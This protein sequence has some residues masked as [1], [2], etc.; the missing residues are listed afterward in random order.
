LHRCG[1]IV[2]AACGRRHGSGNW[3]G[4]EETDCN[5]G[6]EEQKAE[7][8]GTGSVKQNVTEA[9]VS[10]GQEGLVEF[11][12]AGDEE[13]GGYGQAVGG[14]AVT[15]AAGRLALNQA[16]GA[17]A[18][19]REKAVAHEVAGFA[20]GEVDGLPVGEPIEAKERLGDA[21]E[22]SAGVI[23]AAPWSGFKS[24]DKQAGENGQP[25]GEPVAGLVRN[26]LRRGMKSHWGREHGSRLREVISRGIVCTST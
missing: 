7:R 1:L 8:D 25:C 21:A 2:F 20:D 18:Y 17:K 3:R 11:V 6:K 23:C 10:I 14:E 26:G 22:R 19:E 9:A 15:E 5:R 13:C 12:G 4:A 16:E 24:E